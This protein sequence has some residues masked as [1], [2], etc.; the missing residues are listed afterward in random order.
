VGGSASGIGRDLGDDLAGLHVHHL[1]G[2]VAV[3]HIG[4]GSVVDGDG[5]ARER[6]AGRRHQELV[7]GGVDDQQGIVARIRLVLGILAAAAGEDVT[8]GLGVE[9]ADVEG[10]QGGVEHDRNLADLL[11]LDRLGDCGSRQRGHGCQE[12]SPDWKRHRIPPHV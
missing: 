12:Q 1:D 8:V 4:L 2:V 6:D 5:T 10:L 11:E 7:S 9:P 3:A